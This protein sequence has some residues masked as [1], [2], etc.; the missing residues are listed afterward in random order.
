MNIGETLLVF[1]AFVIFTLAAL[2]IND[3]KFDNE[4]SL[5]ETEFKITAIGI[6]QS[7]VEEAQS[8]YYDEKLTDPAFSGVLP[9]DFSSPDSLGSEPGEV[10]PNFDDVDD[11]NNYSQAVNTP[12]ADYSVGI[13]VSYADTLN[14]IPGY[15]QKS[16]YKILTVAV[17][18]VFFQDS[19]KCNYLFSY[20]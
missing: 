17:T 1:G 11:Y 10:Y 13:T 9:L 19:V 5:L 6:A 8:R 3:A 18:S 12:R 7:F 20:H 16:F 15:N 4:N 2:Y 14:Y